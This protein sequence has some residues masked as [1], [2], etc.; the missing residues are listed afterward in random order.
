MLSSPVSV[1][2]GAEKAGIIGAPITTIC[3]LGVILLIIAGTIILALIPVYLPRKDIPNLPS[4]ATRYITL[5][6][7]QYIPPY[8][9]TSY[10]ACSTIARQ[11]AIS[12][13]LPAVA[14]NPSSCTF[15]ISSSRRRRSQL[16]S[17]FRRQTGN[18]K[19]YMVADIVYASCALCRLRTFLSKLIGLRFG[20]TFNYYGTRAVTFTIESI[21]YTSFGGLSSIP[22]T[23]TSTTTTT[24]STTT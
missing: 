2:K 1:D 18:S 22:T 4:T 12:L 7:E 10:S 15:A 8:G 5:R 24:S 23:T 6:P 11:M 14:I 19:L 9:I 13:G 3:C 16:M 17:R 21:R 20:A